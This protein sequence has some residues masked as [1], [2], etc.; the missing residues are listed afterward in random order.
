M[1]YMKLA[2]M[3]QDNELYEYLK[4]LSDK[5]AAAAICMKF[6]TE[7]LESLACTHDVV[8]AAMK[9]V[10]HEVRA[11]LVVRNGTVKPI[12]DKIFTENDIL[13]KEDLEKRVEIEAL[14]IWKGKLVRGRDLDSV[15]WAV[16][17]GKIA[18]MYLVETGQFKFSN[19][20]YHDLIDSNGDLVEIKAYE[21][22]SSSAPYVQSDLKRIRTEGWNKSKY[23]LLFQC[24]NGIYKLLEKIDIYADYPNHL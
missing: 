3:K 21:V 11:P 10:A 16:R 8:Q 12:W 22:T 2:N 1:L 24:K 6:A 4:S 7:V 20:K 14:S 5:K 17:R 19:L 23:M 13:D 18:E 15:K 9:A